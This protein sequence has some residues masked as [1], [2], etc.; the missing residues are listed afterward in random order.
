[1][2]WVGILGLAVG[3]AMDAF[4]VSVSAG[5]RMGRLKAGQMIRISASFG[6]FQFA[7][8]LI[9]WTAGREV[10]RYIEAF[11]HWIAFALLAFV[12]SKMLW[13]ASGTRQAGSRDDP[14]RGTMLLTL[15][16][17]TSIDALA[18][19]LSLAFLH[20]PILIPATV[21][22][23][24]TSTLTALGAGFGSRLG[25]AWS[26]WAEVAGGLVLLFIGIRI[27]VSH[28]FFGGL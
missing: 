25:R 1:V 16:V 4:A 26:R 24:V 7:M 15:S 3:L 27:L 2:N 20:L 22:G 6:L 23:V 5:L 8:P 9:G 14:T 28:L 18:V 17:A 19:G 11:D 10:A 12:G 21:I 13:E